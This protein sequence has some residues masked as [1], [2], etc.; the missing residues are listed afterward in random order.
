MAPGTSLLDWLKAGGCLLM[1]TP[2]VMLD[3]SL[4]WSSR[5]AE[6]MP[7]GEPLPFVPTTTGLVTLLSMKMELSSS[8]PV[9]SLLPKASAISWSGSL[10]SPSGGGV[11][12]SKT[13]HR[14]W[15]QLL[16]A[17]EAAWVL[18]SYGAYW[19]LLITRWSQQ[20]IWRGFDAVTTDLGWT[21][22]CWWLTSENCTM[23]ATV[24]CKRPSAHHPVR[25]GL[26][27]AQ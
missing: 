14:L 9:V 19:E 15:H 8:T 12:R 21:E 26:E 20:R 4:G 25:Q 6:G 18:G 13:Q 5:S 17:L 10:A 16:S 23:D 27:V 1:P 11:P 2:I 3:A 7:S 24:L 22:R